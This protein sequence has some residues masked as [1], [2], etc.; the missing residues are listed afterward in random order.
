GRRELYK[1]QRRVLKRLASALWDSPQ[2]LDPQYAD[3]FDAA[4]DDDS[5]RRVVVDQVASLTDQ[6]A[7]AW[8]GR[9]VGEIDAASLGVWAP[10]YS[11]PRP[12]GAPRPRGEV[13]V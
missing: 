4:D 3:D 7:I 11:E 6:V 1:E 9:L 8:H 12:S 2:A 10:S 13:G 5:R